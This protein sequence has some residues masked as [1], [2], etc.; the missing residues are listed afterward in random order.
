MLFVM[1]VMSNLL[2]SFQTLYRSREADFWALAP[3]PPERIFDARSLEIGVISCWAFLV[4][5]TPLLVAYGLATGAQ[6]AFF[7]LLAPVLACFSAIAHWVGAAMAILLVRLFPGLDFK[8]LL[9]VIGV[10]IAPVALSVA[11]AFRIQK[12][13]PNSDGT[14]ILAA[15]LEPLLRE[16]LRSVEEWPELDLFERW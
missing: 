2:V 15:A 10:G 12:L 9:L 3:L 6:F 8:R 16:A 4:L 5:G 7:L 13:G 11:R 1:L 14:E